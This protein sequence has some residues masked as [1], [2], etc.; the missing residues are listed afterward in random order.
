MRYL[1]L[2]EDFDND[3]ENVYMQT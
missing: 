3:N 1:N 2:F